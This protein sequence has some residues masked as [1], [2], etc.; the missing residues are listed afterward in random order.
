MSSEFV[1]DNL[2][3]SN[4]A[5][6]YRSI[7]LARA[8]E[9]FDGQ[10]LMQRYAALLT[11]L[12]VT[13]DSVFDQEVLLQEIVDTRLRDIAGACQSEAVDLF[14]KSMKVDVGVDRRF[15]LVDFEEAAR[16]VK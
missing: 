14:T 2:S 1:P 4:F 12:G 8:E 5:T 9:K 7:A 6:N 13:V 10:S 11:E 3:H 15:E 16:K